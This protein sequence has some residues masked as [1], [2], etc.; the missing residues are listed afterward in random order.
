MVTP[1]T[2]L[3]SMMNK[4]ILCG[5]LLVLSAC[6]A[7]IVQPDGS[8]RVIGLV[9]MTVKPGPENTAG[10]VVQITSIGASVNWGS[11][12]GGL[13]LGYSDIQFANMKNNVLAVGPF[14][15]E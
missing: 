10:E 15:L 9:D 14:V 2:G 3:E 12:F 11:G 5:V 6:S 4:L 1:S 8:V 7:T 13:T